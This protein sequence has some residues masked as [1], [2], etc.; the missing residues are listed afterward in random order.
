MKQSEKHSEVKPGDVDMVGVSLAFRVCSSSH[1]CMARADRDGKYLL[2]LE[3]FS[4]SWKQ[5]LLLERS[6]FSSTSPNEKFP[7]FR[8]TRMVSHLK[9]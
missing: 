6:F 8:F 3:L 4:F 9:W 1:T 2:H 5:R 7:P